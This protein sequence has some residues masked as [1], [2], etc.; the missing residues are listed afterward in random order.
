MLKS[1]CG[2]CKIVGIVA[3]IG[4][5][6]WGVIGLTGNNVVEG[7]FGAGTGITRIIYILVGI[8]GLG[9][10]ASLFGLCKKCKN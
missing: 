10:L 5:L 2:V 4:A 6:N 7:I 9:L 8:S 1:D 3:I